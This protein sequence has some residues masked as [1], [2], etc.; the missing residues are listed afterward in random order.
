MS[1]I[2]QIIERVINDPDQIASLNRNETEELLGQVKSIFDKER[3]LVELDG[4]VVFIGDTHGDFET[5]KSIVKNFFDADY[6]VFLGDYVD[7]EPVQWG[8]IYTLTYLLLLKCRFPEKIILLK[9]NHEC[10]YCIPCGFEF[11]IDVI[12]KYGSPSIYPRFE[13]VFRSMPLMVRL[14]NVFAAH[15]GIPKTNDMAYLQNTEKDDVNL[16]ESVT[17]NDPDVSN[18]L[19]GDTFTEEDLNQFLKAVQA[20]VFIRGHN[21][22][23]LG[24]SIYEDTCLTIF[25]SR[26]YKTKGNNGILIARTNGDVSCASDLSLWDFSTGDW[27]KYTISKR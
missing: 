4:D 17:W 18:I 23:T 20:T 1:M 16:I 24:Y 21:Y 14:K 12:Q 7:R 13:E 27:I 25:S 10:D 2:S 5:T 19:H 22:D 9:G 8:S 11:K 26:K 3:A 15:A 6:L